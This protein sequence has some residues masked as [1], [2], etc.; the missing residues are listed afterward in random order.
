MAHQR[1]LETFDTLFRPGAPRAAPHRHHRHLDAVHAVRD[2]CA[3][4]RRQPVI[5]IAAV[6]EDHSGELFVITQSLAGPTFHIHRFDG[7]GFKNIKVNLPAG[8]I[9][10]WGWNQLFVE[11][12]AQQWWVP[13][14]SGLFRFP[15]LRS[16][17]DFARVRPLKLYTTREGL[18]GNESVA[19]NGADKL[20]DGDRVK[21]Q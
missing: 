6:G 7:R 12:H 16:L 5:R 19:L 10:T 15:A 4:R 17:D 8:V 21:V 13:T 2:P 9:P 11:D 14:T 1:A 18:S 20:R 3:Q